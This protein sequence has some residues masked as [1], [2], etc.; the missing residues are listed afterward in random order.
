MKKVVANL[1]F[2][3]SAEDLATAYEEIWKWAALP[4]L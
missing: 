2:I 1:A 3:F 4:L